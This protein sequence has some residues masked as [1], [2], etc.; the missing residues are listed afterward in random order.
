MWIWFLLLSRLSHHRLFIL[1]KV[2]ESL[3]HARERGDKLPTS[4]TSA[5]RQAPKGVLH[6]R[7]IG[8]KL[9]KSTVKVEISI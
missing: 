4:S 8:S 6:I 7:E 1:H 5:H 3:S 9:H 2:P